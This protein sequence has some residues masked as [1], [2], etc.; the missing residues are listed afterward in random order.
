MV[1]SA[2]WGTNWHSHIGASDVGSM[3]A[4][5]LACWCKSDSGCEEGMWAG[6]GGQAN[7]RAGLGEAE[8]GMQLVNCIQAFFHSPH[9]PDSGCMAFSALHL[10]FGGGGGNRLL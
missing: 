8:K 10:L 5:A 9:G 4:A 1:T 6:L 3:L 7:G 2:N